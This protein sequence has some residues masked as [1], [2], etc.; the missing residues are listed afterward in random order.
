MLSFM[1]QG[2]RPGALTEAEVARRADTSP[3]RV[4]ELVG[5]GIVAQGSDPTAPF[6]SGDPVRIRLV[7]ELE[8]SGIPPATVAAAMASGSLT[9]SYLDRLPGPA[10]RSGRSY[11][12]LCRELGIPFDLVERIYSG[13]GLPRPLPDENVRQ[14]DAAILVDLPFLFAAGLGEAEVLRAARVWGEGPRL[15]AE[16]QVRSFHELVEEPFRRKGLSDDRALDAALSDVGARLIPFCERLVG[17]LYRRHFEAYATEHRIGH[18]ES[19]L[20]AAGLRRKPESRPE[21]SVFADLS[22]YTRLTD[23]LG[24]EAAAQMALRLAEL[25]QDIANAHGGRFVKMLGDGVHF[26]FSEPSDAVLGALEFVE[27]A[28]TVGLPPAHVGVNAGPMIYTDGDYYGLAVIIAARIASEA[29][30]GHVLVGE[31]AASSQPDGVDFQ[32]LAPFSLKG[33]ADPVTVYRA[34]RA[35]ISPQR[36]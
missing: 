31:L 2:D 22:G 34:V 16:H 17:W 35:P 25:T 12:D 36:P 15:V 10:P 18:I 20:S 11:A 32:R 4:R 3:E 1:G 8:A 21:A 26:I 33:V 30:P 6:R 27:R 29:G 5:L 28:E 19:A 23:E 9:L 24:D 14:E 7:D 13:F